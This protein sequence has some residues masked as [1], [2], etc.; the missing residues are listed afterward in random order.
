MISDS[1]TLI[2]RHLEPTQ[3][4]LP[5]ELYCFTKTSLLVDYEGIQSDIF[6]HLFSVAYLFDLKLT[7]VSNH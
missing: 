1:Q 3:Y 7:Q 4:G 5:L 2:V 6:E